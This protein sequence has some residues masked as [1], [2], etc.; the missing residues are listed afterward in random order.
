MT[1]SSE[2]RAVSIP[3]A[4]MSA[5]W[6]I[7]PKSYLL[8]RFEPQCEQI[9][10]PPRHMP[11]AVLRFGITETTDP[12]PLTRRAA[13]TGRQGCTDR[14]IYDTR[15]MAPQNWAH[16]LNDV[17]PVFFF[18]CDQLGVGPETVTM[19]LP[20]KTPA[21]IVNMAHAIG[22]ETLLS[23]LRPRG[24]C[25]HVDA[26]PY[27]GIR[28]I[29]VEWAALPFSRTL[30]DPVIDQG[31]AQ[32][33]SRIFLSRRG[34]RVLDN[35]AEI[36]AHLQTRGYQTVYP[37]DLSVADQLRLFRDAEEVV[38]VHGAGLAP[39]IYALPGGALRQLVEILPCG[40]M[41]DNF[42]GLADRMGLPWI[43]VRGRLKPAYVEPAYKF[44]EPFLR[45]SL[46]SF[47]VDVASIDV[48]LDLINERPALSGRGAPV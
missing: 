45:Y 1:K 16:F 13:Y 5:A 27:V 37:E 21:F 3:P 42:R 11:G 9:F 20:R 28:A 8:D 39:M 48:A 35:E 7:G 2:L 19:V 18:V 31:A 23:D 30:I 10:L 25:I 43:G 6:L 22:V 38:A 32:L 24:P 34:T 40:H 17:L 44:T 26:E 4:V 41:T 47:E 15:R 14:L 33:P 46:D 36:A 29:R 12:D